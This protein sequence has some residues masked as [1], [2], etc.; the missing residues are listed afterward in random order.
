MKLVQYYSRVLDFARIL[1]LRKLHFLHKMYQI[2]YFIHAYHNLECLDSLDQ[3]Y[4]F[5]I[6]VPYMP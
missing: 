6:V 5:K 1:D 4:I 2:Q 3:I